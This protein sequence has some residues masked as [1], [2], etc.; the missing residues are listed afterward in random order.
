MIKPR[1]LTTRQYV[2]L[3]RDLNSRMAQLPPLFEDSQ[4]LDESKLVDSLANNAPITHKAMLI[5]QG[6]NPETANL[7]TFVEHCER[8]ETTDDIAG[9]KFAASDEDSKPSNKKRTKSKDDHG[10]KRKKRSTKMYCSLHRD[11]TSH[12]S[13]KCNVLK[14]KGKENPKFSKRDFKKK[15]R[16]IDLLEKKDFQEKA[17]YLKYKSLNKASSKTI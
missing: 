16:E 12:T 9:A 5:S 2:G 10:K 17:K 15:S 14:S 13:R 4:M 1:R 7:E 11:N 3:V 8:A 6:F